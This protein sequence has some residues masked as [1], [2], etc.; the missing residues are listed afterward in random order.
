ML[1]AAYDGGCVEWDVTG[2]FPLRIWQLTTAAVSM[3]VHPVYYVLGMADGTVHLHPRE[4][5]HREQQLMAHSA[6]V[7]SCAVMEPNWLFTA[8]SCC[9]LVRLHCCCCYMPAVGV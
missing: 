7:T 6:A 1:S 3:A 9:N 2:G 4:Q 8:S 5:R